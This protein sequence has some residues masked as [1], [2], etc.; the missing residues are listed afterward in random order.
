MFKDVTSNLMA[1]INHGHE[2]MLRYREQISLLVKASPCEHVIIE[3]A[4]AWENGST[5]RLAKMAKSIGTN[6]ISVSL[7]QKS[8]MVAEETLANIDKNF[9]AYN[10]LG[11]DFLA[12]WEPANV[13][14]IY[15]DAIDLSDNAELEDE[16]TWDLQQEAVAAI[17]DKIIPGGLICIADSWVKQDGWYGEGRYAIPFLLDHGFFVSESQDPHC[18]MLKKKILLKAMEF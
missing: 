11:K 12:S 9:K 10:Q 17:Y 1:G 6:F 13:A 7:D 4:S 5:T 2:M 8:H 3:M 15:F 18:V 14:A 16:E